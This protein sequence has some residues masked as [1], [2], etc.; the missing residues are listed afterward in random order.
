[1]CVEKKSEAAKRQLEAEEVLKALEQP[2][3]DSSSAEDVGIPGEDEHDDYLIAAEAC[4][5]TCRFLCTT[6]ML[7][8]GPDGCITY[9]V[10]CPHS[11][12][13]CSRL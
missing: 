5:F 11:H 10:C 4:S 7:Q 1:M 12:S 9:S 8:L 3:E 13:L 2:A 6:D